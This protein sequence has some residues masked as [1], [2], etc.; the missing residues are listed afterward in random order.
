MGGGGGVDDDICNIVGNGDIDS[1]L[2][3]VIEFLQFIIIG[4]G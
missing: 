1:G 2:K 3:N 4:A